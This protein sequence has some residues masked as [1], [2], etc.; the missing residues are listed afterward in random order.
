MTSRQKI[1]LGI[2]IVILCAGAIGIALAFIDKETKNTNQISSL[3]SEDDAQKSIIPVNNNQKTEDGKRLPPDF[4]LQG[5]D[6][7]T[8]ALSQYIGQKPIILDFW[9]SWCHN[10]QRDMPKMQ[11]FYQEYGGQFEI[12][13]INLSENKKIAQDFIDK[14]NLTYPIALDESGQVGAQYG[15]LYTNT[16]ILINKDGTAADVVVGDINKNH[17]DS[18]L[19]GETFLQ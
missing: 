14:H 9:A 19:K 15:I 18:L 12:I 17:I 2:S 6:G 8:I 3:V 5:L 10:C 1:L 4:N 16:H 11:E 7:N 13:A